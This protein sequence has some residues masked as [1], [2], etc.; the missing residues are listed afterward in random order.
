M[1]SFYSAP[2]KFSDDLSPN[3][4]VIWLSQ[5]L[6]TRGLTLGEQLEGKL[7]GKSSL[8]P[9]VRLISVMAKCMHI[10]D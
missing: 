4:L 9:L 5:E 3:D 1:T 2:L 6:M 7:I 10:M 8:T